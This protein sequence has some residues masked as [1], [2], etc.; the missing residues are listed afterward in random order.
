MDKS[1]LSD[2]PSW[3]TAVAIFAILFGILT[4]VSGGSV[5]FGPAAA[6]EMAGDVVWFVLWF[7]V[8]AGFLYVLA[9]TG[10]YFWQQWAAR[11]ALFIAAATTL[12]LIAFGWWALNGSSFEMRTVLAILFRSGVWIAIAYVCR[13]ALGCGGATL[14]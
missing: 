13:R 9:G 6:R 12:V 8:L 3:A 1:I 2:R 10:L 4:I 5:L 14:H 11:L 7:N